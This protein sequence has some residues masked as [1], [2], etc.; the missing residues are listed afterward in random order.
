[1][2]VISN[3]IQHPDYNQDTFDN[4]I[5]IVKTKKQIL[6]SSDVGPTCLPFRYTSEDLTGKHVTALGIYYNLRKELITPLI[7]LLGWG[8]TEFS[9]PKSDVLQ[10]VN[11]TVISTSQCQE[12]LPDNVIHDSQFCTHENDKDSCQSDSGGPLY[13]FEPSIGRLIQVG[14]ISFGVACAT[15][16]PA[17]NTRISSHLVWIVSVTNGK[18]IYLLLHCLRRHNMHFSLQMLHIALNKK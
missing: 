5:A 11:L 3:I 2:H 12:A 17:V 7:A 8:T 1:M 14:A 13:Y 18:Y 10:A 6:F 4:D 9:G 16:R 15:A